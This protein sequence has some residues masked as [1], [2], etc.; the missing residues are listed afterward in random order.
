M[1]IAY[2]IT[3]L[4]GIKMNW[5]T[6]ITHIEHHAYFVDEQ[7]FGPYAMWHHEHHFKQIDGGVHMTD[8]LTYALPYNILGRLANAALVQNEVKKIFEY[9][10]KAINELFGEYK[11]G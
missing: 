9:R 10:T 7:R 1:L 6:E 4:F 5:V 2:K 11:E 8:N 3:P